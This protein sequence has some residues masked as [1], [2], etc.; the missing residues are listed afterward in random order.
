L[1]ARPT[2]APNYVLEIASGRTSIIA[3]KKNNVFRG[4]GE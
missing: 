3:I 4:G 2:D 1:T